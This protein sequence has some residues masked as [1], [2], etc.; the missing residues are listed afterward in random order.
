MS[1]ERKNICFYE[2]NLKLTKDD[3]FNNILRNRI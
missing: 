2:K 3:T 1:Y